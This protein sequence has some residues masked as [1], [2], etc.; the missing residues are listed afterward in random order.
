MGTAV[1]CQQPRAPI[2][3]VGSAAS[4]GR[5][6]TARLRG[7][8]P[9]FRGEEPVNETLRRLIGSPVVVGPTS[10]SRR[11]ERPSRMAVSRRSG[12]SRPPRWAARLQ[13]RVGSGSAS[14]PSGRADE[15]GP[16][17]GPFCQ[18]GLARLVPAGRRADAARLERRR[19]GPLGPTSAGPTAATAPCWG[20]RHQAKTPGASGARA[21]GGAWPPTVYTAPET[22]PSGGRLTGPQDCEAAHHAW[23]RRAP[24]ISP[25]QTQASNKRGKP[26]TA[27]ARFPSY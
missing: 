8:S 6:Q 10:M 26:I 20:A 27:I 3:G 5:L 11:H 14:P 12:T 18:F 1:G 19:E 2:P 17:H 4:C 23:W 7:N 9:R 15:P 16:A 24:L 22:L 13:A 25:E 21:L